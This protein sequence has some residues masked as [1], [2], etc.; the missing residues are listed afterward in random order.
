MRSTV[1]VGPYVFLVQDVVKGGR[2]D[3][4]VLLHYDRIPSLLG[5]KNWLP[6]KLQRAARFRR[7]SQ[8]VVS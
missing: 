8:R 7:D 5:I 1:R 4:K 3:A 2:K 6:A